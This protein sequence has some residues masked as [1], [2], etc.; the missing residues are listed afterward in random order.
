[1][2]ATQHHRGPDSSGIYVDNDAPGG[3]AHNRLSIID[4]SPAGRQPMSHGDLHLVYNGEIYNGKELRRELRGYPFQSETDT[5]VI[6]AAYKRWGEACLDRFV[7]MFAFAIWDSR[8]HQLFAARDRFGIKPFFYSHS[9][10]GSLL[11]ASEIQALHAAGVSAIENDSIWATYFAFGLHDH[12]DQTFWSRILSLPPG[13]S[14]TWREGKLVTKCWYDVAQRIGSDLDERPVYEILEEYTSLLLDSVRGCIWSDVP[15]GVTLSGGLDSSVL[16]AILHKLQGAQ[17]SAKAFTFISGS[18][19]YDDLDS[20]GVIL[21]QTHQLGLLSQLKANDVPALAESVQRHQSE[22]FGGLPTLAYAKL[23]EFARAEGV[24]VTLDGQGIDE[25]W[26]GYDYYANP[27][28]K[29]GEAALQGTRNRPLRPECLTPEFRERAITFEPPSVFPETLRNRQYW[30]LRYKKLPRTLR[31]NDRVSMRASTEL[32]EPFLDHRLVELA[33]R[34]SP[35]RKI[36]DGTYKWLWRVVANQFISEKI[37]S[38]PK[39][40][41]QTPQREWLRGPLKEWAHD[42]IE[43]GINKYGGQWFDSAQ[44]RKHWSAYCS[45]ESD[46]S[47]YVW[48]W[49]NLGLIAN[50][51]KVYSWGSIA[52]GIASGQAAAWLMEVPVW[53][54][55]IPV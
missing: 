25:Q 2:L 52:I 12:S 15:V 31:F 5:E 34:Q 1:M 14:L 45:G 44:V 19:T 27:S 49:L 33:L 23:F 37:V 10:D 42:H 24:I 55:E 54:L 8:N 46:N 50:L 35:D 29:P 47:F 43:T 39:S 11:F 6:L 21:G 13:H 53:A 20:L 38:K 28:L 51:K 22:P 26:A 36:S 7:G 16:S 9:N 30:D 41:V 32:R 40:P 4:R 3:L 17:S 18:S 48:Q